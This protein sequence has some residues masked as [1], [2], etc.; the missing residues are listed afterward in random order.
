MESTDTQILKGAVRTP[1]L[2]NVA[3]TAPYFHDG[4]AATLAD[5]VE[6][7]DRGG[8]QNPNLD[9]A[10]RPLRL[11]AAQKR[12]LVQFLESLTSSRIGELSKEAELVDK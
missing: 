3:L 4:S 12:D 9:P 8:N 2:R 7:Y 1:T 10:I 6:V 5:V 11:S